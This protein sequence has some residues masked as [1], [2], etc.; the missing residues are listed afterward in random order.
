MESSYFYQRQVPEVGELVMCRIDV[1]DDIGVTCRLLEYNNLEAFLPLTEVSKKRLRSLRKVVKV[2]NVKVLQVLRSSEQY[3]DLSKKHVDRK[4]IEEGTD[5][6]EKGKHLVSI[7]RQLAE[8]SHRPYEKLCE[9]VLWPLYSR[10][11]EGESHP[12]QVLRRFAYEGEE[13]PE[14][15]EELKEPL[16]KIVRQ[17]MVIKEMKIEATIELTCYTFEGIDAIKAGVKTAMAD[18][19]E[20]KL[21]YVSAPTYQVWATGTDPERV[22]DQIRNALDRLAQEMEKRGGVCRVVTAP[23][24]AQSHTEASQEES[25]ED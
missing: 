20:V 15:S 9:D 1:I 6:Y 8:V 24:P 18:F 17:R 2:G 10:H 21:Q 16:R 22:G 23:S 5:K 25:S 11:E 14:V 13:I 12:Y 19:P 4:M 7:F 3:I